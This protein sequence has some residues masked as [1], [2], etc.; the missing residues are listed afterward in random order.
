V[1][2]VT[3]RIIDDTQGGI[4]GYGYTPSRQV[5]SYLSN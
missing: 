5:S 3:P 2:M 1:I 4:Y